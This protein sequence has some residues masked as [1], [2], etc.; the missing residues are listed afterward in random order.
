MAHILI[1]GY[2][3][4][5]TAHGSLEKARNELIRKLKEYSGVRSHRITLVFDGWKNGSLHESI[6]KAEN[7]T[8]IYSRIAE[9][10]D[11]VIRRIISTATTPWIVVSSDRAISDYAAKRNFAALSSE[12][13]E[14]RFNAALRDAT[15]PDSHDTP[16]N[17]E[18]TR[19]EDYPVRHR[20]NP[21]K[22]SSRQ[23]KNREA[24][25]KL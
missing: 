24:L 9:T 22:L 13:F 12:Q 6:A 11:Q 5:G 17:E 23:K 14:A 25:K 8:V 16:L 19:H 7:L 20:G 3:L 2:N 10:A 21:R 4:I 15:E 1:D 18:E